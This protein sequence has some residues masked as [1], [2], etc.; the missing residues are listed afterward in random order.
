MKATLEVLPSRADDL[1][2]ELLTAALR[3]TGALGVAD[4][5]GVDVT[6][7]GHGQGF[8]GTSFRCALTYDRAEAGAPR[9][10]IA[11]MATADTGL[12]QVF[13]DFGLYE[14][15][16]RF[17]TQLQHD[18]SLPTPRCFFARVDSTTG[19]CLLVLADLAPAT[20]GDPLTGCGTDDAQRAVELVAKM[21]AQWWDD[22]RLEKFDWLPAA[23]VQRIT[24][25]IDEMYREAWEAF[26]G[27]VGPDFPPAVLDLGERLCEHLPWVLQRLSSAPRTLVHGDYQ[28]GNVF[29]HDNGLIAAVIDWQVIIKA[30]GAMDLAHFVARSLTPEERR[31]S[32]RELV[33][34]Y[35]ETLLSNGVGAY[36]LDQCWDDYRLAVMSQFGLGVL[37]SHGLTASATQREPDEARDRLSMVV[38]GRLIAALE[39]LRVGELLPARSGWQRLVPR[40]LRR[41]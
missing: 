20:P 26:A 22:P 8:V 2:P 36:T 5:T 31:R 24:Q 10:V 38:G 27:R 40:L 33:R 34:H 15:E 13:R 21:H 37:L 18:V 28:M 7:I 35:H 3:S 9:S 17:Y 6:P 16:V 29:Y 32:E 11:K 41:R 30:R 14:R 39:E 19:D 25:G 4:V 12:K 1:T 23:D